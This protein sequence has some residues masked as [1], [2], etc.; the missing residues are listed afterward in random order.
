MKKYVSKISFERHRRLGAHKGVLGTLLGMIC[1]LYTPSTMSI[2]T[3]CL[4]HLVLRTLCRAEG[5][6]AVVLG[7]LVWK[8]GLRISSGAKKPEPAENAGSGWGR[9]PWPRDGSVVGAV[10]PAGH[11]GRAV[12]WA[13]ASG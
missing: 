11:R 5:V 10:G 3:P 13:R 2:G 8:E 9:E 6:C 4:W 12:G 7:S 1:L